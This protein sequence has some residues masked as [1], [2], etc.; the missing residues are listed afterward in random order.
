MLPSLRLA[1]IRDA[2]ELKIFDL[3][4]LKLTDV[5]GDIQRT[6]LRDICCVSV[7]PRAAGS[8]GTQ[9]TSNGS[10]ETKRIWPVKFRHTLGH[11]KPVESS[12]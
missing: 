2:L 10:Y 6:A 1:L 11:D 12:I 8:R 4:V 3:R 7:A 5:R 9:G